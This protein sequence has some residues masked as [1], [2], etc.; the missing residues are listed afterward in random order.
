V[1]DRLGRAEDRL[2]RNRDLRDHK[3]N[4]D[5]KDHKNHRGHRDHRDHRERGPKDHLGVSRDHRTSPRKSVAREELREQV[6]R[7]QEG[8]GATDQVRFVKPPKF[9]AETDEETLA[10]REK[11]ISYGKNTVD[12]DR[13]IE[14]V[15]VTGRRRDQPRTPD[16]ARKYSRRQWDGMVK[17]WKQ[18][19]HKVVSFSFSFSLSFS[20]SISFSFS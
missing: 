2:Q 17:A 3:D 6:H 9:E 5:H 12:Y 18:N 1:F 16:K 15:P 7:L 20:S 14:L 4:M 8:G 13:Y 19:L 11:Q 10:R